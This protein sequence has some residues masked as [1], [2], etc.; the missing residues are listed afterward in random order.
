[1]HIRRAIEADIPTMVAIAETKRVEYEGYAPGFWRKAPEASPK[2][3]RYL[4]SLRTETDVIA[5]V[6][7]VGSRLAG[8]AIGSLTTAPPLSNPGG[9]VCLV[10]DCA[11]AP[12]AEWHVVGSALWEA[13]SREAQAR[14]AVLRV[15]VCARRDPAKRVLLQE[16]GCSVASE[17]DVQPL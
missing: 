8:F 9:P 1:M 16:A 10:D 14:G 3:E 11:V 4:Q 13:M 15:V 7:Q 12:S 6:A 2:H 17:W 5:R